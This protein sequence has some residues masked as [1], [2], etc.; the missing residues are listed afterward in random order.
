MA[1]NENIKNKIQK[2]INEG[3]VYTLNEFAEEL[4]NRFA[5]QNENEKKTKITTSQI[6]NILDDVQGMK[7][8]DVKKGKLQ[9]LRPKLAYLAGKNRG[10]TSLEE[11]QE[12]LSY[13]IILVKD[14]YEK[15]KR[16]RDFFEA[17]VGYHRFY[18]KL[19]D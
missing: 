3:D 5:P 12:V 14:D 2:I 17:I 1:L 8:D 18:N 15:F 7:E 4:G 10:N 9:L 19:R 6:R 13:S 11:L 16:F